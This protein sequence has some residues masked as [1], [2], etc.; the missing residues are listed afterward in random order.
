MRK[1]IYVYILFILMT[2][3]IWVFSG[4]T[5]PPSTVLLDFY[6]SIKS[7]NYIAAYNLITKQSQQI[8]SPEN[9]SALFFPL[10]DRDKIKHVAPLFS[11]QIVDT[12][13][14][15]TKS[16]I[17]Y[18]FKGPHGLFIKAWNNVSKSKGINCNIDN[19]SH[20]NIKKFLSYVSDEM[21]RLARIGE[22]SITERREHISL[23]K[24]NSMWKIDVIQ[25][26][27]NQSLETIKSMRSIDKK[28]GIN[29]YGQ[30][31]MENKNIDNARDLLD[32]CMIEYIKLIGKLS[33]ENV[34]YEVDETFRN[35]IIQS[36]ER[37]IDMIRDYNRTMTNKRNF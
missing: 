18:L 15:E 12:E 1:T 24:E 37:R 9:L 22:Y 5:K 2:P 11:I 35:R 17:N 28:L 8:L 33:D 31:V 7:N 13:I 4:S 25:N 30:I 32:N 23:I 10:I 14:E 36:L 6:E 19:N 3:S 16:R 34:K 29:E 26:E 27:D 20:K 21:V